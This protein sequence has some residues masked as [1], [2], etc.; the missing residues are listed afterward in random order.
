[1]QRGEGS[2][3]QD[4]DQQREHDHVFQRAALERREAFEYADPHRTDRG[5]GIA[6]H[7]ADDGAD[8]RLEADQEAGIVEHGIDRRDQDPGYAG[9]QR[10]QQIGDGAGPR[11]P[12]P[13]Q[14]RAG[15]VHR[16]GAQRF[17]DQ[18]EVEEQIEQAAE[19]QRGDHDQHGL[20]RN[21]DAGELGGERRQRLG[22]DAF[23][24]EEQQAE[25]NQREMQRH[26]DRQQQQHRAVGDRAEHDPVEERGD[27]R[28]QHQ[29]E[30]QPDGERR[31]H[32]H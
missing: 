1:M 7:A 4:R 25:T 18:R 5:A 9:H 23:R 30:Y 8:E 11:R 13:H 12:D 22:P 27:R 29:R 3:D 10:A 20:A 14:T 21:Q 2:P 17:A 31:V 6:G 26:G 16:G 28:D 19:H 32:A 24:A 15:A